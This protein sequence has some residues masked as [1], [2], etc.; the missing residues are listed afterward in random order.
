MYSLRATDHS[1]HDLVFLGLA[2]LVGIITSLTVCFTY[3]VLR[4]NYAEH[5]FQ[6]MSNIYFTQFVHYLLMS[7][8]L[9]KNEL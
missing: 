1:C 7:F 3:A 8:T 9:F 2:I 4:M 6:I 5:T